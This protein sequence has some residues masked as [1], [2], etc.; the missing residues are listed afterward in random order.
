MFRAEESDL[1]GD[2]KFRAISPG[3]IYSSGVDIFLLTVAPS[4]GFDYLDD[5]DAAGGRHLYK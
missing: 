2:P 1:Y 5:D 3:E 4:T